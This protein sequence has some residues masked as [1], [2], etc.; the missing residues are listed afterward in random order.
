MRLN[1]WFNIAGIVLAGIAVG[2]HFGVLDGF[3]ASFVIYA[4]MPYQDSR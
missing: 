3:A 4:L 2:R 1:F